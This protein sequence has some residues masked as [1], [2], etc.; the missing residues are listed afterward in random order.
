MFQQRFWNFENCGVGPRWDWYSA[1]HKNLANVKKK[2]DF[3]QIISS[4]AAQ[5]DNSGAAS[6]LAGT[7]RTRE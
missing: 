3:Y 5:E 6:L 1:F 4:K 7:R 2:I